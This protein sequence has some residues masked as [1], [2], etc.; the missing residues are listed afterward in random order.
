MLYVIMLSVVMQTVT[1]KFTMLNVSAECLMLTVIVK[2]IMLN[3]IVLSVFM[4]NVV[5]PHQHLKLQT[6]TNVIKHFVSNK[7]LTK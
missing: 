2:S 5:A 6:W 1:I 3:V 7:I 4:L